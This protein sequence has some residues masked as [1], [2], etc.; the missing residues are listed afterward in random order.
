MHER[1]SGPRT[2]PR[3]RRRGPAELGP[4][5]R[6]V[7]GPR[8]AR[9]TPRQRGRSQ[10]AG[11]VGG[12]K[13]SA[14]GGA[15]PAPPARSSDRRSTSGAAKGLTQTLVGELGVAQE[16]EARRAAGARAARS[17]GGVDER[18]GARAV[19]AGVARA[20]RSGP[21]RRRGGAWPARWRGSRGPPASWTGSSQ[22][23]MHH[24]RDGGAHRRA[25]AM[26]TGASSRTRAATGA[27][28]PRVR[29]W[30]PY[31]S[32]SAERAC[33]RRVCQSAPRRALAAGTAVVR[34]T[35]AI[36]DNGRATACGVARPARSER[37]QEEVR[38][39]RR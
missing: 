12:S 26:P 37:Q 6:S 36:G 7:R 10:A 8:P 11:R 19:P 32:K 38:G 23:C 39:W 29:R 18:P 28:S 17:R 31:T 15:Q 16:A 21:R 9:R 4:A 13:S 3:P 35:G 34:V 5:T 24:P 20:G 33:M 25:R 1:G 22:P 14:T 2:P 30:S 27:W